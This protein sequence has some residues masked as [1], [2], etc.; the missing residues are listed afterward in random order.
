M[1]SEV[2]ILERFVSWTAE[3]LH[4]VTFY[5]PMAETPDALQPWLKAF[6]TSPQSL[7]TS[8]AGSPPMST[9]GGV[10]GDFNIE[11]I[12]QIGR[13]EI[14]LRSSEQNQIHPPSIGNI[15]LAAQV[16]KEYSKKI[17]SPYANVLRVAVVGNLIQI[18]ENKDSSKPTELFIYN[19]K[20]K[21][22]PTASSDL[23][24][25]LNISRQ[26]GKNNVK[27]NRL[28]RWATTVG[29]LVEFKMNTGS[30]NPTMNVVLI[31]TINW[32][33]DVNSDASASI[34][35]SIIEDL[36]DSSF[37]EFIAIFEGGYEYLIA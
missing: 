18:F 29:N 14:V 17:F 10:V 34:E 20:I 5:P 12:A 36:F 25:G 30:N 4:A 11:I 3:T 21:N 1:P 8:S 23:Q 24:F 19:T 6:G 26:L 15:T 2:R 37:N 35:S 32:M 31:P 22:I 33:I 13:I 7:Q 16:L 27:F 28:C 9:A